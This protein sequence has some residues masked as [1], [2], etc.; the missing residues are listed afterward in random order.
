MKESNN[1]TEQQVEKI[2]W[3]VLDKSISSVSAGKQLILQKFMHGQL[4]CNY[5]N[6]IMFDY[7]PPYCSL[8]N[9]VSKD[10]SHV[11]RCP[12]CPV[13][14]KIRDKYK[15]DLRTFLIESHTNDTTTRVLSFTINAW[16][17]NAPLPNLKELAPE[18][19]NSNIR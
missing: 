14:C 5:R 9:K 11:L 16:L 6:N 3:K 17:N 7:K 15:K 18:H 1:W 12:N 8:C 13:R 4:P 2:W 19:I 10:Q